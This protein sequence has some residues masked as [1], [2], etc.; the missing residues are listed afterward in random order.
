MQVLAPSALKPGATY[1]LRLTASQGPAL[2]SYADVALPVA[3]APVLAAAPGYLGLSVAP[4][5]GV[6]MVT[7]FVLSADG[8]TTVDP[9]DGPLSYSFSVLPD[10]ATRSLWPP[11]VS[12][13]PTPLAPQVTAPP[14]TQRAPPTQS[15]APRS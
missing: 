7:P 8:W 1:A 3:G 11:G 2:S 4:Q 13:F 14:S 10:E 9:A 15:P 5:S 12:Y 6:A